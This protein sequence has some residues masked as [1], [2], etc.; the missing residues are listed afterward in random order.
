MS[1][2]WI[3]HKGRK[4]LYSDFRG[5]RDKEMFAQHQD[6]L[7]AVRKAAAPPLLLVNLTGAP[8]SKRF[9]EELDASVR[10]QAIVG[11]DGLKSLLLKAYNAVLGGDLQSFPTEEEAKEYLVS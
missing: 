11:V 2:G 1:L 5:L 9:M 7:D 8:A 6:A 3:E 4:I 10:R